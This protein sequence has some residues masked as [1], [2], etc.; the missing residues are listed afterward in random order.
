MMAFATGASFLYLWNIT[1]N[2]RIVEMA[3]VEVLETWKNLLAP[4]LQVLRIG[5]LQIR[6]SLEA[7]LLKQV[8]TGDFEQFILRTQSVEIEMQ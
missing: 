8:W 5:E 1:G 3:S 7:Q 4:L 2:I 6:I